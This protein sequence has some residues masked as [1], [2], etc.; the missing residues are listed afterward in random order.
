MVA[1]IQ[2]VARM[3]GDERRYHETMTRAWLHFVAVHV[4]RWG[5]DSFDQFLEGNPDLLDRELIGHFYSRDLILSDRARGVWI[6]PDRRRLPA[7][8]EAG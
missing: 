8:A 6:A 3:H 5:A 2:H 1:A 4:Q 7:L